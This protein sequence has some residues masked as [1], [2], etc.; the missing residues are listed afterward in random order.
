M[1]N[2]K[3]PAP[4]G[5][6]ITDAAEVDA[7][8]VFRCALDS[9]QFKADIRERDKYPN[10][11]GY[12]ELIDEKQKPVGKLEVQIKKLPDGSKTFACST[13]LIAYT[14]RT[15]L[16]V[17]LICVDTTAKKAYWKHITRADLDGK[18][19]QGSVSM[20]FGDP[21]DAVSEEG[22]HYNKWLSLAR[23]AC[24]GVSR[25]KALKEIA[26]IATPLIGQKS[27]EIG[28]I[29]IF[30]D[31][32]NGLLDRDFICLK[33]ASFPGVYSAPK[34]SDSLLRWILGLKT[35]NIVH[36]NSTKVSHG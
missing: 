36:G 23:D 33:R 3:T 21:E 20:T 14:E 22:S 26:R 25:Y 6:P 28:Q 13:A 29:Q 34:N 24:E 8:N 11:D 15:P 5:Y 19:G 31:E 10:I 12:V 27:K 30:I 17:L 32:L 2:P 7:I 16:P 4:A 18:E 35:G 1:K 9:K